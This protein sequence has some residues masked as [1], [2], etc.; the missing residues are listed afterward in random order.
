MACACVAAEHESGSPIRP[1]LEDVWAARFLA[2]SVKV[3]SFNKLQ[4]MILI[5]RVAYA[6]LEPFGLGLA[7]ARWRC[8]RCRSVA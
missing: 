6:N 3:Q 2:D 8:A 4:N 5:R 7:H 1:A